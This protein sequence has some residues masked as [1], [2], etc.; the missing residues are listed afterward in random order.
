M[1]S[2][3]LGLPLG[4]MVGVY[5]RDELSLEDGHDEMAEHDDRNEDDHDDGN[6]T[7]GGG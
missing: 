1:D 4:D 2:V 6:E 7:S 5:Q 3:Q